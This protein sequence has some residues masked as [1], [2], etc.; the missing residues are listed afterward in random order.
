MLLPACFAG[1]EEHIHVGAIGESTLARLAQLHWRRRHHALV[2][3][4]QFILALIP[5]FME[6]ASNVVIEGCAGT[7]KSFLACCLAKQACRMRRSARYV[8]LRPAHGARRA[9]SHRAVGREDIEEIRAVRAPA[10]GRVAHGRRRR[11]RHKLPVR[12]DR[13]TLRG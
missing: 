13:A 5:Q 12:A 7:G 2:R 10:P 6:T 11:H 8:R 9:R 3:M 1:R 4:A